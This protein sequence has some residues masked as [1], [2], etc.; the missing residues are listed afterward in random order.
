MSADV[1]L[2][3][4]LD[5]AVRVEMLRQ[6]DEPA[7]A[8]QVH[9][10]RARMVIGEKGDVMQFRASGTGSAIAHLIKALAALA[11][12]PG[13]VT[14]AGKH[15]CRNHDECKEAEDAVADMG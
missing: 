6:A 5:F 2:P 1:L 7:F 12:A 3:E 11:V 9:I 8:R 14:F 13:G 15:W 10:D 4:F